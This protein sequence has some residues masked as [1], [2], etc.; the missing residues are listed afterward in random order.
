MDAFWDVDSEDHRDGALLILMEKG[1]ELGGGGSVDFCIAEESLIA[2]EGGETE[3]IPEIGIGELVAEEI[4]SFCVNAEVEGGATGAREGEG[5][6]FHRLIADESFPVDFGF[7][8]LVD[9][10]DEM[11]NFAV[12]ELHALHPEVRA[13]VESEGVEGIGPESGARDQW[14]S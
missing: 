8:G 6:P 14:V 2:I 12:L 9:F 4:V 5:I 11:M 7:A 1:K 10:D 3:A 13:I